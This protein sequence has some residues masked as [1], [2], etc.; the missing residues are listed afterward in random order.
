MENKNDLFKKL[1]TKK[2]TKTTTKKPEAFKRVYKGEAEVDH[3]LFKL[4]VANLKKNISI[5]DEK[6]LYVGVEHC[7]F[8][9]SYD[10]SG[11]KQ[12]TCNPIAGHSHKVDFEVDE[13]GELNITC[14]PPIVKSGGKY[15]PL[16]NDTHT[17]DI[18]YLRSEKIKVRK[19]NETANMYIDNMTSSLQG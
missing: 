9:H 1:E 4:E 16:K 19:I 2:K 8:F 13:N 17:H 14:G 3:D 18:R 15:L 7:H 10:S 5:D 11:K 6:P 12:E